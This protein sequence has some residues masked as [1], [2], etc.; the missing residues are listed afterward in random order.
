MAFNAR[1]DK[2][3]TVDQKGSVYL[4]HLGSNRFALVARTGVAGVALAFAPAH[5][6][7]LLVASAD[8]TL[9]VYSTGARKT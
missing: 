5:R 2:F 3:A 6:N 4:F 1:G 7:E 9:R 8:G